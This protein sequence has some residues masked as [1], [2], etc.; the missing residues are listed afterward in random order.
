MARYECSEHGY[1]G[2]KVTDLFSHLSKV[3]G[4]N[5]VTHNSSPPYYCKNHKEETSFVSIVTLLSHINNEHNILIRVEKGILRK[6]V[7]YP[8]Y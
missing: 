8:L 7:I 2:K 4:L 5:V 6:R 1:L 3:H